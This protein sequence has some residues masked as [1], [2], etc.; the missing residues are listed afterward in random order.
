MNAA[1]AVGAL[2]LEPRGWRVALEAC[3]EAQQRRRSGMG[4]KLRQRPRLA[5]APLSLL[6]TPHWLEHLAMAASRCSSVGVVCVHAR[7]GGR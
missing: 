4:L 7:Q 1:I 6:L 3:A 5:A 2:A